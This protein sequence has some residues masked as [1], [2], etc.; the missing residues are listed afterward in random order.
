MLTDSER[1]RYSRQILLFGEEGQERLKSSKVFIAGA[2]GLGCPAAAYLAA[3]GVGHLVIADCDSVDRTNL[4]RQILHYESD[5]GRPKVVSAREKLLSMN[6][7]IR[8]EPLA[9]IISDN[10]ASTLVS[11]CDL[12]VD[13][14]DTFTDRYALNRA[15][16]RNRIP[17]IH[18][19]VSGF[20][21]HMA[22]IIPGET[23]CLECMVPEAPPR[24]VFPVVGTTPGLIGVLQAHEAIKQ[25]TGQGEPLTNQL[26]LWDG[27][28][29]QFTMIRVERDPD[30]PACGG[31]SRASGRRREI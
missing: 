16:I 5:I 22:T 25:I 3:A 31:D 15:A 26:V 28:A 21:G 14:L 27:K 1:E 4:N 20:D 19:A 23:A 13:A 8:V 11:G 10:N 18:G 24:S 30:C 6:P 29:S 9:V 17:Y 12:V 2:G 7:D